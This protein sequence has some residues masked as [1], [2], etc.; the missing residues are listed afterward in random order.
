M[1][2]I[3]ALISMKNGK[4]KP[5]KPSPAVV[6]AELLEESHRTVLLCEETI[7]MQVRTII[8]QHGAIKMLSDTS[9]RTTKNYVDSLNTQ[10]EIYEL[11]GFRL[12]M[13]ML[14]QRQLEKRLW[15]ALVE[16]A[17]AREREQ[18]RRDGYTRAEMAPILNILAMFE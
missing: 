8:K 10:R 16:L 11:A 9:E 14:L 6:A 7:R 15:D 18:S 2:A 3:G 17:A 12:K 13:I 1:I 5:K 4:R